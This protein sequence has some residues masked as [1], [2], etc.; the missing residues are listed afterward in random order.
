MNPMQLVVARAIQGV[1]AAAM[2]PAALALLSTTFPAGRER[3]KAFGIWSAMNAAGGA[4][5]VVIGGV[6]TEYAGWRWVMFV[7]AP[8]AA[9]ALAVATGIPADRLTGG[10]RSPDVLGPS[11]RPRA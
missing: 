11:W 10:R 2:A 3:V 1:G 7:N 5:G 8:I 4:F 9:I 6:L